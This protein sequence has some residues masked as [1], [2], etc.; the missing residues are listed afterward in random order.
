MWLAAF[1]LTKPLLCNFAIL[2]E[3]PFIS[4]SSFHKCTLRSSK[5]ILFKFQVKEVGSQASVWT[6]KYNVLML[7]SQQHPSGRRG[8]TVRTPINV[9]KLRIVQ[10]C[11]HPDV[12][13]TFLDAH[14]CSTRNRISF[15]NTDIGRQ[16]HPSGRQVY[17]VWML[18]LIRQDVEKN[19]NR[20]DVKAT[21][22]GHQSLL[23]KFCAAY[24]QPSGH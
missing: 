12:S 1:C 6:A 7:I 19:C 10:G 5:K 23:W 3:M 9:Q 17:T 21:P 18:S 15:S 2:S 22:S 14:Q 24:V 16:L 4:K 20:L 13:A 11:I 8:N